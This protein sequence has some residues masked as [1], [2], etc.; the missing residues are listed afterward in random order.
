MVAKADRY[1]LEQ[2]LLISAIQE[3]THQSVVT[4]KECV[5]AL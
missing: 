4:R 5:V 3:R 2:L 1:R